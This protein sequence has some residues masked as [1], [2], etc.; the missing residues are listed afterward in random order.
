MF[1]S[2]HAAFLDNSHTSASSNSE[3]LEASAVLAES[4]HDQPVEDTELAFASLDLFEQQSVLKHAGWAI[5]RARSKLQKYGRA[6][7][8]T[9]KMNLY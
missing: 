2:Y 6:I 8:I 1:S 3:Q 7:E 9:A 5:M 4:T